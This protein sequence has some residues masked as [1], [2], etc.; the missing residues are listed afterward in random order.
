MIRLITFSLGL[1]F[2]SFTNPS[3]FSYRVEC[4]SVNS[5]DGTVTLKIW[6]TKKG[7]GYKSHT[8][9]M[10]AVHCV[11]YSG[12][13]GGSCGSQ[14]PLLNNDDAISKFENA[15]PEFFKKSG[16]Y[17]KYVRTGAVESAIPS[18]IGD[19][20][21]KVYEVVVNRKQLEKNLT[22]KQIKKRLNNGF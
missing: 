17:E 3:K 12:L 11:L 13:S 21:W 4:I 19:K 9:S 1:L 16:E 8:G 7:K 22:E 6:D 18:A 20:S 10:N 14:N 2:L 5:D 15:Y